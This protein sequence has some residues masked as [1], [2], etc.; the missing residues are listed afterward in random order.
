MEEQQQTDG[1]QQN[2]NNPTSAVDSNNPTSAVEVVANAL[3]PNND[4]K[5]GF[6]FILE[7]GNGKQIN[8]ADTLTFKSGL[9]PGM[10]NTIVK[11]VET[12][13]DTLGQGYFMHLFRS[14]ISK[15]QEAIYKAEVLSSVNNDDTKFLASG[16]TEII[17]N[18]FDG[19]EEEK[20]VNIPPPDELSVE[21]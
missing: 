16:V 1:N 7:D 12:T 21:K 10:I 17:G 5:I 15:K 11:R 20:P 3:P 6:A 9:E 19:I 13:L 18:N 2:S 8:I 4:F 14:Y